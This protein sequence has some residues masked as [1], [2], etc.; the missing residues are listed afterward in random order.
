[1][2]SSAAVPSQEGSIVSIMFKLDG[3][4]PLAISPAE[5]PLA[6]IKVTP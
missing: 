1:V 6:D 4:S 2:P 3:S 5:E